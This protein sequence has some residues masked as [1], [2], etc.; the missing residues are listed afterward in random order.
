MF[1]NGNDRSAKNTPGYFNKTKDKKIRE[2]ALSVILLN[3][4]LEKKDNK[5]K[6]IK[7]HMIL[8]PLLSLKN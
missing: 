4:A 1:K 6:G 2:P 5:N 7:N 3:V 8:I